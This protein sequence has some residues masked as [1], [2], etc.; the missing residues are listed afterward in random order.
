MKSD[1]YKR[2]YKWAFDS[3]KSGISLEEIAERA[4]CAFDFNAFDRGALDYV[5][6][7]ENGEK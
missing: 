4:D 6:K 7:H 3:H 2:G 5:S 1:L